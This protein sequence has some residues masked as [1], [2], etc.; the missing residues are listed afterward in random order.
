MAIRW[1]EGEL[2]DLRR[3][4]ARYNRKIARLQK[5]NVDLGMGSLPERGKLRTVKGMETR[6]ELNAFKKSMER[7]MKPGSEALVKTKG[8]VV[9]PKYERAEI[10]ALNA[11]IN[12]RRRKSWAEAHEAKARGDL[13][14]MGRIKANEAKPRKKLGDVTP[15]GYAEYK[16]VAKNEGAV[17]YVARKEKMY[18]QN[19]YKMIDRLYSPRDA[20]KIKNRLGKISDHELVQRTIDEEEIS[21]SI[22]SPVGGMGRDTVVE[23]FT[24]GFKRYFPDQFRTLK[25]EDVDGEEDPDILWYEDEDSGEEYE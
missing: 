4:I 13:P 24:E 3:E 1:K 15:K 6:A 12:A 2:D 11:R 20:R 18:R 19:Y 7:F 23:L 17:D 14:L 9:I 8:G 5:K 16:R 25:L 22:G 21:F 10:N